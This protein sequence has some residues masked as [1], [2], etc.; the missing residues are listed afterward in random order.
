MVAYAPVRERVGGRTEA[1]DALDAVVGWDTLPA[2]ARI[3][4]ALNPPIL[5]GRGP[6]YPKTHCASGWR[7][8]FDFGPLNN[9]PKA[10]RNEDSASACGSVFAETPR[11]SPSM[12][13]SASIQPFSRL[14][15]RCAAREQLPCQRRAR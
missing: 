3:S 6:L 11:V 5:K 14:F 8:F 1:P 4:T 7:Q 2:H 9:R 13:H 12:T 10:A 15:R